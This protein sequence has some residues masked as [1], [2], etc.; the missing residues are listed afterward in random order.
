MQT[1]PGDAPAGRTEPA[2]TSAQT[3]L[4]VAPAAKLDD[5]PEN[6]KNFNAGF[7]SACQ[8][9]RKRPA[10]QRPDLASTPLQEAD[11]VR[12]D[13]ADDHADRDRAPAPTGTDR[14]GFTAGADTPTAA[15]AEKSDDCLLNSGKDG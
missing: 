12:S 8:P 5:C 3:P 4:T 7:A 1:G 11:A 13:G 14:A 10:R 15:P 2:P 6:G 9:F